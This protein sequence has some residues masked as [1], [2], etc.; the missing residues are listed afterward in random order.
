MQQ[1]FRLIMKFILILL[2]NIAVILIAFIFISNDRREHLLLGDWDQKEWIYEKSRNPY[3]LNNESDTLSESMINE[4]EQDLI[5]HA[6]EAWEF[7]PDNK[8]KIRKDNKE[9]IYQWYLRGRGNILVIEKANRSDYEAYEITHLSPDSL[10]LSFEIQMQLKGIT[11]LT[12][13]KNA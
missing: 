13:K 4:I 2:A 8:L 3:I 5:I 7:L 12:F 10:A 6:G 1:E 11:R 9:E